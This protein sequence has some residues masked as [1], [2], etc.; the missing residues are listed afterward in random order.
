MDEVMTKISP[1]RRHIPTRRQLMTWSAAA[2]LTANLWPGRLFAAE[3]AAAAF[4]FI[5]VNDIHSHDPDCSPWF[6]KVVASMKAQKAK[7]LFCFIAGDVTEDGEPE[8]FKIA[9]DAFKKLGLPIYAVPGNHDYTKFKGMK[10]DAYNEAYPKSINYTFEEGGWQFLAL[11]STD[12]NKAECPIGR[13]TFDYV[14]ATLAKLDKSKPIVL[15]THFPL[16]P[17]VPNRS[18]NGDTL[19]LRFRNHN[20]A[21]I[22]GGHHHGYTSTFVR[23]IP[24]KTNR[25]CAHL[26]KNHDGSREKGY[27]VCS[28]ED[29]KLT[30]DFVEVV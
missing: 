11:D 1:S 21:A 2:L 22:F 25:C 8:Q 3:K 26:Q 14:D 6:A 9:A 13:P 10:I 15:I 4:D 18:I 27:F 23:Q 16:G 7:P 17:E 24:I 5:I 12:E 29:G 28:V 19:L 30:A 20:L